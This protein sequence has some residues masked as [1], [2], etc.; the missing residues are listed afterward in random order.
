MDQIEEENKFDETKGLHICETKAEIKALKIVNKF[1][2]II[3]DKVNL[4]YD[5][6][7]RLDIRLEKNKKHLIKLSK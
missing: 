7:K 3:R 6:N 4:Y 2:N 5:L 1:I